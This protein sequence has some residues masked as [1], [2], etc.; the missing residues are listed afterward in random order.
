MSAADDLIKKLR[1]KVVEKRYAFPMFGVECHKGWEALYLPLL[2]LCDILGIE[3]HQVKEKFGGLRFYIGGGATI[4]NAAMVYALIHAMEHMSYTVCEEC[5]ICNNHY[6]ATDYLDKN[7][8]NPAKVTTEG[9]WL[10]T[11]CEQC[12]QKRDALRQEQKLLVQQM[13]EE[14]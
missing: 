13:K 11:L 10:L 6:R 8:H 12:R 3:V 4:E 14:V 9:S 5:G 7:H 1:D 2:Q